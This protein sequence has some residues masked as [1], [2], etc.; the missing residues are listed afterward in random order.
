MKKLFYLAAPITLAL[1]V[2]GFIQ[3]IYIAPTE[4]TMG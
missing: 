1:L 2:Y 3:A 4:A